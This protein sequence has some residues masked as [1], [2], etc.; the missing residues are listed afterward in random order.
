MDE[1]IHTILF[2]K[3]VDIDRPEYFAKKHKKFCESLNLLGKVL[4]GKE[5]INGSVTGNMGQIEAYKREMLNDR[6]FEDVVFKEDIGKVKPFTKMSV[7][8]KDEII[9]LKKT[10]DLNKKAP[11]ISPE[12]LKE[13]YDRGEDFVI[14]DTRNDYEWKVGKFKEAITLPIKTFREFPEAID[15][16]K[17]K[18]KGKKIVTYCTGGIRCE[19]ATAFMKEN[20]FENEEVYQLKDG[21][22]TFCK[23]FPDSAWEG[24]CFVFDKR[25][26]GDYNK[27]NGSQIA[28]CEVCNGDCDLYRNCRNNECDKLIVMCTG[29]EKEMNGCCSDKCLE[30][31]RKVCMIKSFAN[32][33]RR[34]NREK[35]IKT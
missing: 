32:Q 2:Y 12:S 6:R 11:Y 21:I 9:A 5:G 23:E 14:L 27:A 30:D 3:F 28:N 16:I 8:V 33:G 4:V 34:S 35:L 22:I 13:M 24:K 26:M 1:E 15:K 18:I 20:G 31:F 19:K 17:D 25:L 10:I 7:L 29:C